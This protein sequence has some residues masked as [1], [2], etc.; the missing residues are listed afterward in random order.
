[1]ANR[2]IEKAKDGHYVIT[3]CG[4]HIY[5]SHSES[6]EGMTLPDWCPECVKAKEVED[7]D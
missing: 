5:V 7:G 2:H 6:S 4:Q 1:M 3:Y